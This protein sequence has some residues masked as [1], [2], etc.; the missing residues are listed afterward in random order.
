MEIRLFK[1]W[2]LMTV[3]GILAV[4]FGLYII[5]IFKYSIV[6]T[7]LAKIFG[8][9]MLISGLLIN[10]GAV[11]HKK[12][13]PRWIWWLVEGIVDIVIGALFLFKPQWAKAFILAIM[14]FWACII[15]LI[16]IITAIRMKGYMNNWWSLLLTGIFSIL[17]AVLIFINPLYGKY[18]IVTVVGLAAIIFG[19]IMIYL[20]KTLKDVYL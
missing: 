18:T 15:G 17:F 10:T 4:G 13:N 14:A 9:I 19:L 16:Q 6:T 20:S 7:F 3:K 12:T 5:V 1:N 11:L 8:F 2:W